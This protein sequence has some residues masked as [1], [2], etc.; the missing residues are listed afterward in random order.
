MHRTGQS[1]APLG[2]VKVS[3]PR[4]SGDGRRGSHVASAPPHH[5]RRPGA[6]RAQRRAGLRLRAV[7]QRPLGA[8]ALRRRHL[9][10]V[11]PAGG[12]AHRAAGRQRRRRRRALGLHLA[13]EH[14]RLS[15]EHPGRA[16]DRPHRAP[17]GH[18]AD[19]AHAGDARASAARTER[20]VL[21]LVR[22]GHRRAPDHLAARRLAALP[23]PVLGRQR[24]AGHRAGHGRARRAGVARAG[25]G[26]RVG[27]GLRLLLRPRQGPAA[28]R[29]VDRAAPGLQ[30]PAGRRVDDV[31]RLRRPE[32]RAAHRQLSGHRRGPGPA[33]R[34]T[35]TSRAPS[36]RSAASG[37]SRRR[38]PAA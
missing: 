20:P 16:R 31:Q 38:S 22:P 26:A 29:R 13:D 11:R 24:L 23:L 35:S 15:V 25:P 12:R 30:R 28:R 33:R 5:P 7:G 36:R 34:T 2:P 3:A 37:T 17:R 32:L 4:E 10:L 8:A 27:D 19:G 1:G 14:R 6:R 21:Q 18:R 9:A